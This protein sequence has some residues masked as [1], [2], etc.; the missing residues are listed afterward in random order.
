MSGN[1]WKLVTEEDTRALSGTLK[2][3]GFPSGAWKCRTAHRT[4][5]SEKTIYRFRLVMESK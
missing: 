1:V 5:I 2:G 3:G 4:L